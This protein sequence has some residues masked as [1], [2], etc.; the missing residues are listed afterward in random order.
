MPIVHMP[1]AD[2]SFYRCDDG[3][4]SVSSVRGRTDNLGAAETVRIAKAACSQLA[5]DLA[6]QKQ[7]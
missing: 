3:S 2:V 5:V 1:E 6:N 7:V 4:Y